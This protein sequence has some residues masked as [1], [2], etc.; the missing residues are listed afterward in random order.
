MAHQRVGAVQHLEHRS[1]D[2]RPG[3]HAGAVLD[4]VPLVVEHVGVLDRPG[5]EGELH[6]VGPPVTVLGEHGHLLHLRCPLRVGLEVGN[7]IE[8]LPRGGIDD[9]GGLGAIG[10]APNVTASA[11]VRPASPSGHGRVRP[12][13]GCA[14]NGAVP[15]EE[16]V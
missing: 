1:G 9:D 8:H 16:L 15:I 10:H 3:H 5:V 6:L 13:K 7:D 4:D 14:R 2:Q 11:A 12:M